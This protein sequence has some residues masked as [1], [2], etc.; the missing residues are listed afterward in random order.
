MTSFTTAMRTRVR[1]L[2]TT[3]RL[4]WVLEYT[5]T[6]TSRQSTGPFSRA[7][8]RKS[9]RKSQP[10]SVTHSSKPGRKASSFHLSLSRKR[11]PFVTLWRR[12]FKKNSSKRSRPMLTRITNKLK[13]LARSLRRTERMKRR[14]KTKKLKINW[15][16]SKMALHGTMTLTIVLTACLMA[17]QRIS[18]IILTT[19]LR[20]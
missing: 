9:I 19:M 13:A 2:R 20:R 5:R 4:T 3:T 6:C 14:P 8:A 1:R 11:R 16:R 17:S 15:R 10:K 12:L 18:T 7:Q